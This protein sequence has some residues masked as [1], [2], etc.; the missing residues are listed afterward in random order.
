LARAIGPLDRLMLNTLAGFARMP[1]HSITG[2]LRGVRL[3]PGV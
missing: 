3:P 2:L 1:I